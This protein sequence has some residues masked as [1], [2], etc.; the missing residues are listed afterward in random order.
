MEYVS[1]NM[2]ATLLWQPFGLVEEES[3]KS[4]DKLHL[5]SSNS[6]PKE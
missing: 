3:S 2:H 6:Y 4:H 5:T 1:H